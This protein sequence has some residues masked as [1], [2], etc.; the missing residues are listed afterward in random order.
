MKAV[1]DD[2]D[3]PVNMEPP[4]SACLYHRCREHFQVPALNDSESDG[5]ECGACIADEVRFCRYEQLLPILDILGSRLIASAIRKAHLQKCI[6]RLNF[7]EP[8]AGDSML[9]ELGEDFKRHTLRR[10]WLEGKYDDAL[11]GAWIGL[12][13]GHPMREMALAIERELRD[14]K[15]RQTDG[16]SESHEDAALAGAGGGEA[17][18]GEPEADPERGSS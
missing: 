17:V 4:I 1:K 12:P 16:G 8:G 10:Q 13:D 6:D 14:E 15:E 7:I 2:A 5:A 9:Q 11:R 18:P 3:L